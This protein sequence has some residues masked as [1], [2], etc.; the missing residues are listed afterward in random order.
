MSKIDTIIYIA[1]HITILLTFLTIFF[2]TY[3]SSLEKQK[4]QKS[5]KSTI[6]NKIN[7]TLDNIYNLQKN[8]NIPQIQWSNLNN[9]ANKLILDSRTNTPSIVRNNNK[10]F[11]QALTT[12]FIL[13]VLLIIFLIYL[14]FF[15]PNKINF[16][17]ILFGNFSFFIFTG[18][19]EYLFFVNISSKYVPVTPN[20]ATD[21]LLNR[22]KYNINSK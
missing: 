5:L 1:F 22:L 6:D 10:L 7:Y 4:I 15:T 19:V 13:F 9:F 12:I 21:T 2:F 3:V 18:I 20:I 8:N 11:Y 17:H 14:Q 16:K